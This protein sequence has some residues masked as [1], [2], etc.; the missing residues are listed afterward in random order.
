VL[1]AILAGPLLGEHLRPTDLL[2][3]AAVLVGIFI[4]H[5]TRARPRRAHP[6]A[7]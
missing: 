1:T 3:G 4:V 2:G 7:A 5:G 6:A